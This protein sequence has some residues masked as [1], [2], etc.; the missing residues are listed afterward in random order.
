[1]VAG[2]E[3]S[4]CSAGHQAFPASDAASTTG[5]G[6]LCAPGR[7]VDVEVPS[8]KYPGRLAPRRHREVSYVGRLFCQILPHPE[9]IFLVF[10]LTVEILEGYSLTRSPLG[11]LERVSGFSAAREAPQDHRNNLEGVRYAEESM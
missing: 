6:A 1:M 7:S 8:G 5:V 10:R 3:G 11:A 2:F 9:E 4:G